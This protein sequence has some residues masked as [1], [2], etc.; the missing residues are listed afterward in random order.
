M[1]TA[2]Q[3]WLQKLGGAKNPLMQI[4][5]DIMKDDEMQIQKSIPKANSSKS[6]A[7]QGEKLTSGGPRPGE[8]LVI[9][10]SDPHS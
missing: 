6:E 4:Q 2:Q 5:D 10:G 9:V 7:R 8:R 3:V 1:S